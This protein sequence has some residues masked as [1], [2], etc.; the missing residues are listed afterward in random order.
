MKNTITKQYKDIITSKEQFIRDN[1]LIKN[2]WLSTKWKI[3]DI[4]KMTNSWDKIET[5]ITLCPFYDKETWWINWS[6][7]NFEDIGQ[8]YQDKLKASLD[9]LDFLW[10]RFDLKVKFL[11]ADRGVMINKDVYSNNFDNDIKSISELY[12][13]KISERLDNYEIK[14]FTDLWINIDQVCDTSEI[15]SKEE[16]IEVLSSFWVFYDKFKFSLE[17]IINSF[18]LT[19][20]Y[21]LVL[22]Y[23]TENKQLIEMFDN[24]LLINT[25]ATSPLNS[26]YTAW[27]NKFDNNNLFARVD[28]NNL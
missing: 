18:W 24:T 19:W 15:K 12:R 8:R 1:P 11:L 10:D 6:Y 26:L 2:F 25:E 3:K 4:I 13:Y 28:I 7:S 21:Y 20:A 9:V 17:I 23:L 22:N 16:I 5:Y 14:T 27:V